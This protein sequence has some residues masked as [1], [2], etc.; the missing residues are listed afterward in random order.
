[1]RTTAVE[2]LTAH[3]ISFVRSIN[4]T[5][6]FG[7]FPKEKEFL[8][9]M[10]IYQGGLLIN[11]EHLKYPGDILHEAGHIAVA[12]LAKRIKMDGR[13]GSDLDEDKGEEMMAIAW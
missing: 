13:L 12:T 8:P 2:D 10:C 3:I 11:K 7:E 6:E 9:C 4:I 5:V 1:M